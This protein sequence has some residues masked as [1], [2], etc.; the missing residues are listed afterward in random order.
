MTS[1]SGGPHVDDEEWAAWFDDRRLIGPGCGR[2][3][4]RALVLIQCVA[5]VWYVYQFAGSDERPWVDHPVPEAVVG[6]G[7]VVAFPL[8]I[9]GALLVGGP[10]WAGLYE[11]SSAPFAVMLA[12]VTVANWAVF[13]SVLRTAFPTPI[14]CHGIEPGPE[15]GRGSIS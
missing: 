5:A 7:F 12:L 11:W 1:S 3:A 6:S 8:S 14:R 4:C 15:F 10:A 13:A 2:S 9:G